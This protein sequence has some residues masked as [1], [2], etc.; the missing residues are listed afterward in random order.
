MEIE[1]KFRVPN[2]ATFQRLHSLEDL[3][4]YQ[5][6]AP[7]V[8]KVH[9][10]Y[11]DTADR[12]VLAAGYVCRRRESPLGTVIT[13]K[14]LAASAEAVHRREEWETPI[15]SDA[16]LPEWPP[17]PVRDHL[18][19]WA[20]DA[21]LGPLVELYQTR[22]VRTLAQGER[23]VAQL[24]LDKVIFTAG[25]RR[26]TALELEIELVEEG[27]EDDLATLTS[28]LRMEWALSPEPRSKFERALSF[29][30][31]P[32]AQAL[33]QQD[34]R[35]ALVRIAAQEGRYGR[36]AR[37]LLAVDEGATVMEA[38][39]RAPLSPPRVRYWLRLLKETRLD[40]FPPHVR[41]APVDTGQPQA[42]QPSHGTGPAP[43][44]APPQIHLADHPG[45]EAD[46]SMAEAARKT[47]HFHL[48]RMLYHESGTRQGVDIEELHDMRVATRRMRAALRVFHDYLN[49]K[50]MA[51][52]V[53]GL[54]R[55]GR[56]LGAVRDLDV[57]HH[58]MQ[59]YLDALPPERKT[60]LDP[61]LAAWQAQRQEARQEMIAFLDSARYARFKEQFS[62]FLQTPGRGALPA[63]T[64]DGDLIPQRVRQVVPVIIHTR[65]ASVRAHGE[66]V[67]APETPLEHF[68]RLRIAS[69]E[70]RYALE[71]FEEVLGP[72]SKTLIDRMKALQDHLGDLQDAIVAC[73][74]LRDFLTWGT[75][76]HA[77]DA[78]K[79]WPISPVVAPGVVTYLA[80]R[81]TEIQTL[82]QAFPTVWA[83][84]ASRTFQKKLEA[85]LR[86][87]W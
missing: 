52:F 73:N 12:R 59:T 28:C 72:E 63:L 78:D 21:P 11:L 23:T 41:N 75:W 19:Q 16:P 10:T 25:E 54:R 22:E 80:A 71:F 30:E 81:Q 65:L 68:H 39:R 87:L 2:R 58:K 74:L 83:Q 46:D 13:L 69:K 50:E 7:Q 42:A 56:T 70:L 61:L 66:W 15:A 76:G 32:G 79:P 36:R 34:E 27:N 62:Q 86:P 51:P 5:L 67:S 49:L 40:I 3:C 37:A 47:L 64:P 20:G 82:V 35:A 48:Q 60:E 8:Q 1:A 17:G 29:L 44:P 38:A 84:V 9:D 14:A 77:D 6:R 43:Q 24:S 57:F 4:G 45:I 85:A 31:G 26:R 18:L 53:K 33:L 55:A